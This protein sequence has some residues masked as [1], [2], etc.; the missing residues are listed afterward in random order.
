MARFTPTRKVCVCVENTVAN[1]DTFNV[2][3]TRIAC[4]DGYCLYN[5][6][7]FKCNVENCALCSKENF[8]S[9]CNTDQAFVVDSNGKCVY[10]TDHCA[11]CTSAGCTV[12]S[13]GYTLSGDTCR[14]SC[15]ITDCNTCASAT[16]CAT[17]NTGLTLMSDG[18]CSCNIANCK[19]C[20][21]SVCKECAYG[22]IYNIAGRT[23]DVITSVTDASGRIQLRQSALALITSLIIF[24]VM[25]G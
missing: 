13:D 8:C 17:C 12:C 6:A 1:C 19:T 7:C 10:C 16:A 23:C 3:G 15:N 4:S 18:T 9:Q 21:N 5:K 20:F 25:L 11:T 14:A 22:Y 24:T 2:N